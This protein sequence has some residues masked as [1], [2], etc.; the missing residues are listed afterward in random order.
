MY[1]LMGPDRPPFKGAAQRNL[2]CGE[3]VLVKF[4]QKSFLFYLHH[5]NVK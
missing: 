5:L 2:K 3:V 1:F 4:W